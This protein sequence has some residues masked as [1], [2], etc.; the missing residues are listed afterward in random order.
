MKFTYKLLLYIQHFQMKENK[1]E[2]NENI[3]HT[4][5]KIYRVSQIFFCIL[6]QVHVRQLSLGKRSIKRYG[7]FSRCIACEDNEGITRKNRDDAET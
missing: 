1:N 6:G 4:H 2:E 7:R 3:T 5:Y